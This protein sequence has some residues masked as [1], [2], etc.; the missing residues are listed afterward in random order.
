MID[1]LLFRWVVTALFVLS[2]AQFAGALVTGRH[3]WTSA[4]SLGLHLAMAVGM[5]AMAWP[6]G[7]GWPTAG[8]A[9][10]FLL[11]SLWYLTMTIAA[12][13]SGIQRALCS[14]HGLMMLAMAW[15]YAVMDGHLLPGGSGTEQRV[16]SG[17][18]MPGM[19]MAA[20]GAGSLGWISA[21]DWFWFLG[22]AAAAA[23]W[24][25]RSVIERRR[26]VPPYW[27]SWAGAAA[28]AL[29]A[30]GMAIMFGGRL[31]HI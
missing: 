7:A 6:W 12:A 19:D 29:M 4:L 18:S 5:V 31:F 27:H 20:T 8:A 1:D 28:Q 15:M 11:A 30:A 17:D 2:G 22:F 10:F 25:F 16:G 9:V 14:Y 3:R 21:G 24:T 26:G 23:L 13:G